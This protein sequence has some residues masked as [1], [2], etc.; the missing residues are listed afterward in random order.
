MS[1]PCGAIR[2]RERLAQPIRAIFGRPKSLT[3]AQNL[4]Y[5][6]TDNYTSFNTIEL[7]TGAL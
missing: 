2:G 4:R 6:S 3:R 7:L 1:I 5:R